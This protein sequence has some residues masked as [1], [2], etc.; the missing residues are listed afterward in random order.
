[1]VPIPE[2]QLQ[3][4]CNPGAGA[5]AV[6]THTSIRYALETAN[7]SLVRTH[8][9][10]VFLQGSYRNATNI[11]SDSDVDVVVLLDETYTRDTSRLGALQQH[12]EQVAF[13]QS[14]VQYPFQ[15]FRLDV[16]ESLRRYYGPLIAIPGNKAI[17]VSG[18]N[19]R[20]AADVVPAIVHKLYTSYGTTLATAG[21]STHIEGISFWD[22]AGRHIVNYPK[23]H[24]RNGQAKNDNPR[25]GG[26][27]KPIVR[28]FKNARAYMVDHGMLAAS[29]APSYFVECLLYNVPDHLFVANRQQA[30]YGICEWLRTTNMVLFM[31][32][33]GV[34]FLFGLTEEQWNIG[35]AQQFVNALINLW[36]T[37]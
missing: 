5:T 26:N 11:Y 23:E 36:N 7:T 21:L 32:Q 14:P 16:V 2:Q 4:W 6:A 13:Q 18:G 24:I 30:M 17:K 20:I 37:W 10:E 12:A 28:M 31:C 15:Q 1:M 3:T 25:T 27:Y 29:V 19:G 8:S 22:Q 9:I 35:H 34:T 33:N